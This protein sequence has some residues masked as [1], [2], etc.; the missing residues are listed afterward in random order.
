MKAKQE[1]DTSLPALNFKLSSPKKEESEYQRPG[2]DDDDDDG[3]L[4]AE[5]PGRVEV[6]WSPPIMDWTQLWGNDDDD[7]DGSGPGDDD[8]NDS[9]GSYDEGLWTG[10]DDDK[11]RK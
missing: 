1:Q 7:D 9:N 6:N 8:H 5:A 3:A 10:S 11:G 2:C 4:L